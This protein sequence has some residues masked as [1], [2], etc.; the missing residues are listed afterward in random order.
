MRFPI[1]PFTVSSKVHNCV[2]VRVWYDKQATGPICSLQTGA[3][4]REV[5]DFIGFSFIICG[6]PSARVV[7]ERGWR[8]NNKKRL[9]AAEDAVAAQIAA[10]SGP[11]YD[12]LMD[13]LLG[14]DSGLETTEVV[15]VAS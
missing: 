9:A 4:D 11:V 15:A 13:L 3:E 8:T 14:C 6:S 2:E 7:V 1:K 10:K 5:A 12:A